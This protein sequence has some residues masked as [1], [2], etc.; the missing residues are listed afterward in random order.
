MKRIIKY[1]IFVAILSLN[2]C[3]KEFLVETDPNNITSGTFY[4]YE[5]DIQS[6]LYG[7][8]AVF[9]DTYY[10][11]RQDYFTNLKARQVYFANTAGNG[12]TDAAFWAQTVTAEH[13][14]VKNRWTSIYKS[15]NRAN[16]VLAHLDDDIS[17]ST[18]TARDSYEAEARFIRALGHFYLVT[19]WG[20]VPL[21][22]SQQ[23][24]ISELN[25]NYVRVPKEKV[26][27]AIIDD[28]KWIE[29]S[30]LIDLQPKSG[31]GRASKV[32]ALVL[33]GKAALHQAADPVFSS[34]KN[35]LITEAKTAL[36]SAWSKR[37]FNQFT[38]IPFFEA[39]DI[40]TQKDARENI[41]QIDYVGGSQ[42]SYSRYANYFRPNAIEDPSKEITPSESS[43]SETVMMTDVGDRVFDESGDIRFE[44]YMAKAKDFGIPC[45]YPLKWADMT[46]TKAAPYHHNNM[47]VFRYADVVLM[48]AEVAYKSNDE[49]TARSYLNMVRNRAGLGNCTAN[50]KDLRDMILK[51]RFREFVQEGKAWEDLIRL[52]D[53]NELK[54]YMVKDNAN[55]FS[56][57][58]F[59]LPIPYDQHVL[60]RE[61]MWQ[62]P[63][64]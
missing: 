59:L 27:Q 19:E 56:D 39:W 20:D 26:Y 30:P 14:Y 3:S 13:K 28:C 24:S 35:E 46:V 53:K 40:K 51:E 57:K 22:L 21:L 11:T 49:T 29:S 36:E 15:I 42:T 62:N 17:Y 54:E 64:Y 9:K 6:S 34:R 45:Y 44:Q 61:G 58:D 4:Q 50:G 48:L 7:A 43:S 33:H 5:K 52:L 23:K 60:N 25:A 8:Y 18:K 31:C 47:V 2:S 32:A 63:G 16:T 1:L 37:P 38:D 10:I 41:F 55:S 12:G